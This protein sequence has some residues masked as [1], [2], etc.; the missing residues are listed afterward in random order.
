MLRQ[1]VLPTLR[2]GDHNPRGARSVRIL[3]TNDDGI[4]STA[5]HRLRDRLRRDGHEVVVSAPAQ[6]CPG[7]AA[8]FDFFMPHQVQRD[9]HDALSWSVDGS[10]AVATLHGL[11]LL[12]RDQPFDLVLAGP[13]NGWSLGQLTLFS[14]VVGAAQVA[15]HRGVPAIA[16]SMAYAETDLDA[17]A[18]YVA[19]LVGTLAA[20][21]QQH[22]GNTSTKRSTPAHILPRGLGL[23]VNL[24]RCDRLLGVAI[25]RVGD[26]SPWHLGFVDSMDRFA[27]PRQ[28]LPAA[29]GIALLDAALQP[30]AFADEATEGRMVLRD[31][32]TISPLNVGTLTDAEAM[33]VLRT[34]LADLTLDLGVPA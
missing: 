34:K 5:L 10:P 13:N 12:G 21:A 33:A 31:V 15:L 22:G 30:D 2:V 18:S 29:P 17:V 24:P 26:W 20:A 25:T 4:G 28:P 14:G 9:A 32:M 27:H 11:D 16:L 1:P 8:S 3:L 6:P 19:A 23:N 7:A